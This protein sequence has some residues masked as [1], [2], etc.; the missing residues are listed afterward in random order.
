MNFPLSVFVKEVFGPGRCPK[1]PNPRLNNQ[2]N[3]LKKDDWVFESDSSLWIT[4]YKCRKLQ[5]Y[6]ATGQSF[7]QTCFCKGSVANI[8]FPQNRIPAL[9]FEWIMHRELSTAV[10]Y[11]FFHKFELPTYVRN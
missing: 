4:V 5:K 6:R 9:Y 1:C 3:I 7:S 8:S 2:T 10:E 11:F